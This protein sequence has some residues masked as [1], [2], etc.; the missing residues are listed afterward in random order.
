MSTPTRTG[1]PAWKI[2]SWA[3][4]RTPARSHRPLIWRRFDGAAHDIVHRAQGDGVVK[5]VADQLDDGPVGTVADQHLPKDQLM[6]PGLAHG[7][8]EENFIIGRFGVERAGQS[9]LGGMSLLIEELAAD[10]M[11]S[12]QV[13]DWL[14][15]SQHLDTQIL[16]LLGK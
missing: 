7:Q 4:M 14:S 1:L 5:E 10:L 11:F 3:P 15:P 8:V 2:S 13:R 6:Q 16:P 9:V 12:G